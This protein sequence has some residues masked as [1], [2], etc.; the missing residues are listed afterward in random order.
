M[1]SME[2]KNCCSENH[3]ATSFRITLVLHLKKHFMRFL[4]KVTPSRERFSQHIKDGSA[5]KRMQAILAETKPE[6]AYFTE[7]GGSRAALLVVNINDVSQ[8]PAVAEPWFL[9][10]DAEVE[11]HPV[12]LGEDLAKADITAV[13]A[14]WK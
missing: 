10:F 5:E 14:K 8:V 4:V 6:A 9:Q 2:R 12:M 11:F 13:A 7:M 3:S 1:K